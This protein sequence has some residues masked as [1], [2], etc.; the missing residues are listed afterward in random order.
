MKVVA[1]VDLNVSMAKEVGKRI[2]AEAYQRIEDLPQGH[3]NAV[4]I[5][6][7]TQTHFPLA[8]TALSRGLNVITEKP[9]CVK[10]ADGQMLLEIAEKQDLK[11]GV[12]Q[13]FIYSKSV[14]QAKHMLNSGELG[15]DVVI[16]V[17]FPL[18]YVD[19]K[20]WSAKPENGGLLLEHGIHPS[21]IMNF[22]MGE[23]EQLSATGQ[24]PG[25]DEA[26]SISAHFKRGKIRGVM[27][28]G[29]FGRYTL[30]L[31]GTAKELDIHL[32]AD[33]YII[34][35]CIQPPFYGD[36]RKPKTK[37]GLNP[38]FN[39]GLGW[40]RR[41]YK[42]SVSMNKGYLKR[43]LNYVLHGM[44]A[45]DQQRLFSQFMLWIQGKDEFYSTGQV[46][47]SAVRTLERIR[48]CLNESNVCWQN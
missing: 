45:F 10:S 36:A 8:R 5:C 6:T 24:E 30:R 1:V 46:G 29:P 22:L 41:D 15:D 32:A 23:P 7:P 44:G 43:G 12:V 14:L 27:N 18:H 19:P 31:L 34:Q 4:D 26:C 42:E 40:A 37:K 3:I 35:P 9:I 28:L 17:S 21:Y 11:L 38:Y 48:S 2:G 25:V 39:S 33:S 47:V 13:H 20:D 16:E